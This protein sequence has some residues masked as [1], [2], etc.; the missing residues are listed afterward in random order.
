MNHL[1]TKNHQDHLSWKFNYLKDIK[2]NT[3]KFSDFSGPL[4]I[5]FVIIFATSIFLSSLQSALSPNQ[6]TTNPKQIE[7]VYHAKTFSRT[8]YSDIFNDVFGI[9]TAYAATTTPLEGKITE[10]TYY[11]NINKAET[12]IIEIKIKNVGTQVWEKNN[13]TLETG[14]FLKSFSKLKSANWDKFFRPARLEQN[15]KPGQFATFQLSLTNNAPEDEFQENFQLVTNEFP[16]KNTLIR[17]FI[18]TAQPITNPTPTNIIS[19]NVIPTTAPKIAVIKTMIPDPRIKPVKIVSITP[20]TIITLATTTPK[21]A[22]QA[23]PVVA[24]TIINTNTQ[25]A[26]NNSS[27][28]Q[29]YCIAAVETKMPADHEPCQTNPIETGVSTSTIQTN[30]KFTSEPIMRI[31]LYNATSTQRLTV[32]TD[33]DIYTNAL[34]IVSGLKANT[35]SAINFDENSKLYTVT[36]A[37]GTQTSLFPIRVVPQ[38]STSSVVTLL[39]FDKRPNWNKGLNDNAFR[40]IIEFNYSNITKKLWI[41]NELPL[42]QYMKGLM[43]T[44]NYSPV[45]YQKAIVTAA[46]T[47]A[48]YHYNRGVEAGNLKASTKHADENFHLEATYDQVYRGY[49]S[50]MRLTKLQQAVNETS[51]Q[52]ITYNNN[53]VVTPYFS[54]SDGRTRSWEEVWYGEGK[55]WLKSVPV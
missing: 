28:N 15:I 51:G 30:I 54:T 5:A 47:Y 41:I 11:L 52:A 12:K 40:N 36:T 27:D 22:T 1:I 48:L 45:E 3:I 9:K 43:E 55:P 46:R 44:S 32:S 4:S 38:N 53:I 37:S 35:I 34:L 7:T 39:D 19:S 42:D 18:S 13:V 10:D 16:I 49:N 20:K 26:N 14:P 23:L 25:V 21:I 33:Y 24:T 8:S 2:K 29:K 6:K 31:G 17:F 50:E